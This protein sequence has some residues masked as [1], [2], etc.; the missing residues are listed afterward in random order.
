MSTADEILSILDPGADAEIE[1]LH[2]RSQLDGLPVTVVRLDAAGRITHVNE[3]WRRFVREN[4]KDP[5]PRW[6][7]GRNYLEVCPADSFS[8]LAV[9]A[10]IRDIMQGRAMS[11]EVVYRCHSS[12]QRR[13]FRLTARRAAESEVAVIVAHLDITAYYL[14]QTRSRI[15]ASVSEG[16][17]ARKP[18][19]E[20][21]R[22]LGSSICERLEW[23]YA[24]V[25]L[26][27]PPSWT[28]RCVEVWTREDCSLASVEHAMR[29]A[30][31][32]PGVGLPGRAWAERKGVWAT[33]RDYDPALV[34]CG[35][36]GAW[37]I[38][39]VTALAAGFTSGF[40]F[41][42]KCDD[43]VL[44]VIEV[45]GRIREQ[46]D[47]AL[48]HILE[49]SGAQIALAELRERAELRAEAAQ[50]EADA[51]RERLEAVLE[52]TPAL[53]LAVDEHGAIQFINRTP[54]G[55]PKEDVIGTSW[56]DQVPP[57]EHRRLREALAAVIG[58]GP[59]C[60]FEINVPVNGG[61]TVWY[62]THMGP[63]RT[64]HGVRGAVLIA[65]DVTELRRTEA[66]L[67][68]S[69]RLA[70][71][72]TLAAGVAHEIN[73]PLQ[74]IGDNLEFLR[75]STRELLE[76]M[77]RL[78]QLFAA[79]EPV[80]LA[81][82]PRA[83]LRAAV[84]ACEHA[85]LEYVG[86]HMPK[87]LERCV[88]G[89]ERV[90]TIVRSLKEF[91]HPAQAE[92]VAVDLNRAIMATLTVARNEYKY[93]ADLEMDLGDIPPVVCHINQ[94]NQA[95]LNIVINA[96]HSLADLHRGT[97]RRGQIRVRTW[98]EDKSVVIAIRDTGGGIP[99]NIRARIFDPF[100]TTKEVGRGTGQGLAI[101][102]GAV[103]NV[104]GGALT[105]ESVVGEGTEFFI[106]LPVDGKLQANKAV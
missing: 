14:A 10:G 88:D 20:S 26:L 53:V 32:G 99:E 50:A 40:A 85:D 42:L 38:L 96:S 43:D 39:P 37:T 36:N 65:E 6:G 93:V 102:W 5:A 82:A 74:F 12:D 64:S 21:C 47:H 98:Q 89:L 17:A 75:D 83:A 73:T 80:S 11:C 15:Q 62:S 103:T 104:H 97:E 52:S 84:A 7:V 56:T 60:K 69:Q 63:M 67:S 87:A 95:V 90:T 51:A 57:A 24:S 49:V 8:A 77:P 105:F 59:P 31:L 28:L 81:D 100:F 46:P 3:A 19:L 1:A 4:H 72:G 70:S 71:I 45:F 13:W 94:I 54:S 9:E 16:F 29:Q 41:P 22:D 35:P 34:G 68:A 23:D 106:R 91:S 33:D 55:F 58:G 18:F 76:L 27:D 44:A 66:E 79:L 61:Q 25:W 86:E 78:S 2:Y 30:R 92:M 101:A 48:L